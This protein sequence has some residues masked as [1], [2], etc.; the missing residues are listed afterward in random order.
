MVAQTP[1]TKIP[2]TIAIFTP[3]LPAWL[4]RSCFIFSMPDG[5]GASFG[6]LLMSVG[7][8][9]SSTCPSLRLFQNGHVKT[10]VYWEAHRRS[11]RKVCMYYHYIFFHIP[12]PDPASQS[13]RA[14]LQQ[15]ACC[16]RISSRPER[17][18]LHYLTQNLPARRRQHAMG[19]V[20]KALM[21]RALTRPG[22]CAS[23]ILLPPI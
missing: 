8:R 12:G 21:S 3:T 23:A 18:I 5:F 1:R 14:L 19:E 15:C 7:I 20:R 2:E 9:I 4:T 6:A 22:L 17:Q 13:E 16:R 11:I 10:P